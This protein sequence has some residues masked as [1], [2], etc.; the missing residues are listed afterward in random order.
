MTSYIALLRA[1]N[2][3]GTTLPMATLV[4]ICRD[5]GFEGARTHIASGNALFRSR[6]GEA[7]IR[8][9]LEARL[10]AHFGK[11]GD[12]LVRTAGEMAAVHAANPFP[13]EPPERTVAYFLQAAPPANA[14][15]EIR[16]RVSERVTLGRREIYVYYPDGIGRSKLRIPAAGSGTARNMNTVARLAQLAASL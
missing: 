6:L 9:L 1:V 15:N 16:G 8:A 5:A 12:V 13:R 2:V 7:K 11:P 10:A 4:E 14:L 3:G